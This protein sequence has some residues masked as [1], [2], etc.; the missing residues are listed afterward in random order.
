[1]THSTADVLRE[2]PDEPV[3][4]WMERPPMEVAPLVI[5]GAVVGAFLLGALAVVGVMSLMRE[6]G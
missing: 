1:M 3:V 6:Q 2:A 5:G 4:H